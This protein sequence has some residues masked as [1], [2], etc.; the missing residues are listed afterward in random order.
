MAQ[1]GAIPMS[2]L[3]DQQEYFLSHFRA[4]VRIR[5]KLV[6]HAVHATCTRYIQG[7]KSGFILL[8]GENKQWSKIH[9]SRLKLIDDRILRL[10][11]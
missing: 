1:L 6:S 11:T 4:S 10:S 5:K 9:D 8:A 3:P 7:L 2:L